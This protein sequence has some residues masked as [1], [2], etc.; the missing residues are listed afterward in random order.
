VYRCVSIGV[1]IRIVCIV[2]I[3]KHF[4][5]ACAAILS[6][7][8]NNEDF[9]PAIMHSCLLGAKNIK[10]TRKNVGAIM[11]EFGHPS[12]SVYKSS[13]EKFHKLHD[14]LEPYLLDQFGNSNRGHPN[15]PIPMKLCLSATIGCY[16]GGSIHDIVLP[17]GISTQSDFK[18]AFGVINA[19]N[20]F[21]WLAFNKGGAEFPSH[22]EQ[23]SIAEG[24]ER[25]SAAHFGKF[26]MPV[27]GM[28][29]LRTQP[30]AA[31][32]KDVGIGDCSFHC[33]HKDKFGMLL[34]SGC[35]NMCKFD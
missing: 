5:L 35:D 23:C 18:S 20:L 12:Y 3:A 31:H 6:L 8:E 21:P 27:D 9:D 25:M 4:H 34:L 16:C 32:C 13:L 14:I 22:A 10:C 15:G 1:C 30:T 2:Y 29:V 28:L 11:N 17:Q 33:Y 24:F 7:L 19:A 26:V